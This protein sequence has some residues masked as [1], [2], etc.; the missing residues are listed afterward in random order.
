MDDLLSGTHFEAFSGE[1]ITDPSSTGLLAPNGL[2]LIDRATS[3]VT[4]IGVKLHT[5]V[6]WENSQSDFFHKETVGEDWF[7]DYNMK[8]TCRDT[9]CWDKR[10]PILHPAV[11]AVDSTQ[12][13]YDEAFMRAMT[14]VDIMIGI[15]RDESKVAMRRMIE[16]YSKITYS[17]FRV[18]VRG[19]VLWI[20]TSLN[21]HEFHQPTAYS[22]AGVRQ[23][24]R[25]D[26]MGAYT[27]LA[28]SQVDTVDDVLY[29]RAETPNE[30][31]MVETLRA[32]CNGVCPIRTN[33]SIAQLWPPLVHPYAVYT[34]PTRIEM[35]TNTLDAA[36]VEHTL[37]RFCDIFDC[38]DLL[39]EALRLAQ[40]FVARPS[41]A[42][43]LAGAN[44][45]AYTCPPS[46]MR[47]GA[48][49]PLLAGISAE[50]MRTKPFVFPSIAVYVYNAAVKS[51]F[52]TA[53]YYESLRKFDDTHPVAYGRSAAVKAGKYRLLTRSLSAREFMIKYVRPVVVKAGWDCLSV[54]LLGLHT[55][56]MPEYARKVFNAARIPWWTNV[57]GHLSKGGDEFL[58][59]WAQ[60]ARIT[61]H[62]VPNRWY[63][64]R[65]LEGVTNQQLVA[66]VRWL[67]A[68]VMYCIDD[69]STGRKWE[70][71][72]PGT[73]NRFM[74]NLEPIVTLGRD[75]V[76]VA[77]IKFGDN[78]YEKQPFLESLGKARTYVVKQTDE[79]AYP[80]PV[81]MLDAFSGMGAVAPFSVDVLMPPTKTAE[82]VDVAEKAEEP[83]VSDID[84]DGISKDLADIRLDIPGEVLRA[85][86]TA[87]PRR[88]SP[89]A[90]AANAFA[91]C[92]IE[93]RLDGID[94][95]KNRQ[96]VI[97]SFIL[98]AGRLAVHASDRS[99]NESITNRQSDAFVLLN[100]QA[101]A[102]RTP[103][104]WADE[105]AAEE[106]A[107]ALL[108]S[109]VSPAGA[110]PA[111]RDDPPAVSETLQDFG[112][113]TSP[114][115]SVVRRP[116]AVDVPNLSHM[117]A[118]GF[119][120][121]I[122]SGSSTV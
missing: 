22:V 15:H 117:E 29:I 75:L 42:G 98:T 73:V 55:V 32:L 69:Y 62:P 2:G 9:D 17:P 74:P 58:K 93:N 107:T 31:Y 80:S 63:T 27:N 87:T 50:G 61:G 11:A 97:R 38:H 67:K 20:L 64:Y 109:A 46:D 88:Y 71:I 13:G 23:P 3:H 1:A 8:L 14:N 28:K 44:N 19:V 51:C 25:I 5:D 10:T 40:F 89:Q 16:R 59:T 120:P 54:S 83:H 36:Q 90:N 105:V 119:A 113:R 114:A 56:D 57:I 24:V 52:I 68:E 12:A 112:E 33:K 18:L 111:A 104:N 99:V 65:A 103:V 108:T 110:V 116:P 100:A 76:G 79:V 66:A 82:V 35:G 43:V 60:P 86:L 91:M 85:A 92:D 53:G 48:I 49:G 41:G 4:A 30:M 118:V 81:D 94:D 78:V 102:D 106:A 47:V 70:T 96:R 72:D 101:E 6:I 77:C 7:Y 37:A 26:D 115:I 122:N 34:A 84:W 45:I 39:L 121:P 21:E 95:P